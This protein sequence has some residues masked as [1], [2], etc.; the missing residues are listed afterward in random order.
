MKQQINLYDESLRPK[1]PPLSFQRLIQAGAVLLAL[2]LAAT[3][4]LAWSGARKADEVLALRQQRD[5]LQA[6]VAEL[7]A[8]FPPPREDPAL[9]AAVDRRL[10]EL[11]AKQRFLAGFTPQALGATDGFSPVLRALARRPLDG[12]WLREI[13]LRGDGTMGLKGGAMRP[14]AV[15]A[16]VRRLG[17][18]PI[19]IGRQF[20]TLRIGTAGDAPGLL[21]F[22]LQ[23]REGGE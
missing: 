17:Q 15:P 14:E 3:A 8:R 20:R 5:S 12:L 2:L 1:R 19:F 11:T 4:L 9:K 22:S 18:E 10:A 16:F 21:E 13:A 23:S 6:R 7:D